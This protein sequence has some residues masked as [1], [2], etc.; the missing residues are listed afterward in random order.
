MTGR[1]AVGLGFCAWLLT[2]AGCTSTTSHA[3]TVPA[4]VLETKASDANPATHLGLPLKTG[5][6]VLSEAPGPYSILFSLG[7]VRFY[8]FTH[9]AVLVIEDGKP[10]V[11]DTSGEYRPGFATRPADGIEGGPRRTPFMDY[12]NPQLYVELQDPPDGVD[13]E[14]VAAFVKERYREGTPFDAHFDHTNTDRYFCTEMAEYALRAGG[15]APQPLIHVR[16]QPSLQMF[17]TW[18]GVAK[19]LSWPA[20]V[21]HDPSKFVGALGQVRSRSEARAYFAA[22]RELYRRFSDD[23]KLGNV[24]T[25]KGVAD[26]DLRQEILLFL[27][28]A[29]ARFRVTREAPS[30]EEIQAYVRT[31]ADEMFGEVK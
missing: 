23:Q 26:I 4:N 11:Y 21:Y 2:C 20:G 18:F 15:R 12:V 16:E 8:P 7:P 28:R 31:I 25:I 13:P 10:F 6:L 9:V 27:E 19:D 5:M 29:R 22:K 17:L 30:E 1:M 24:F 3:V 14:K